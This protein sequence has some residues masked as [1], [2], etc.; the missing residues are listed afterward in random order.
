MP[1]TEGAGN[2]GVLPIPTPLLEAPAANVVVG[3]IPDDGTTLFDTGALAGSD[4][5]SAFDDYLIINR[6]EKDGNRYMSGLTSPDGFQGNQV[7]FFQLAT[8]TLLWICDWTVEVSGSEQPPMPARTAPEG[9]VWLDEGMTPTSTMLQGDG[10][11]P[12]WR[13]SGTYVYG[14]LNPEGMQLF[15]PRPPW[16]Q[17]SLD[18]NVNESQ[19]IEGLKD[20]GG[21]STESGDVTTA[22]EG[23]S[24]NLPSGL[25][26]E[27]ERPV[28]NI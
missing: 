8:S 20:Y 25:D 7:A 14:A 9:W 18:R 16:I 10:G 19:F 12:I 24:A 11:V 22:D 27:G 21:G 13:I 15:Y 17:D 28:G 3:S 5:P 23:S 26:F 6:F 4:G 2:G 1:D